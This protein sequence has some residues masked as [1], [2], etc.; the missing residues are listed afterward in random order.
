MKPNNINMRFETVDGPYDFPV[1]EL[2]PYSFFRNYCDSDTIEVNACFKV[3][4]VKEALDFLRYEQTD[5]YKRKAYTFSLLD[6]LICLDYW[7]VFSHDYPDKVL[8]IKLDEADIDYFVDH[9]AYHDGHVIHPKHPD[10]HLYYLRQW[11]IVSSML[12]GTTTSRLLDF[13][14]LAR[15]NYILLRTYGYG[16]WFPYSP[17]ED[18]LNFFGKFLLDRSISGNEKL[19]GLN[20]YRRHMVPES[21]YEKPPHPKARIIPESWY[22]KLPS[23]KDPRLRRETSGDMRNT[24][25]LIISSLLFVLIIYFS[26]VLYIQS[27]SYK[28]KNAR[29]VEEIMEKENKLKQLDLVQY[30]CY[31]SSPLM[32]T[33]HTSR[34]HIY[35]NWTEV[36]P[37]SID[38]RDDE[39]ERYGSA[40]SKKF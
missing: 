21:W 20:K 15:H 34:D 4:A 13:N 19:Y 1:D 40:R 6:S 28:N 17:D 12:E 14:L 9:L 3:S 36:S 39:N 30:E 24:L 38:L 10:T 5:L 18:D 32:E 8:K 16:R 7:Q 11:E 29:L 31:P 27:E 22:K 26:I 35:M 2:K 37:K 25:M 23:Q 33:Y